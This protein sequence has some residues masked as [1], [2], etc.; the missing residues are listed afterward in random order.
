MSFPYTAG[1]LVRHMLTDVGLIMAFYT[2][3]VGRAC[4][5]YLDQEDRDDR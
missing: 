4:S 3:M 1:K 5:P 2:T